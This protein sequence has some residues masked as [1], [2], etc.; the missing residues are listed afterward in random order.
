MLKSSQVICPAPP[1][2]DFFDPR[3]WGDDPHEH[4]VYLTDDLELY[5]V[6]D[7]I[8]Y[9]HCVMKLNRLKAHQPGRETYIPIRWSTLGIKWKN[10]MV[11]PKHYARRSTYEKIGEDG[12]KYE[13]RITGTMVRNQQ[14]TVK[15]EFLHQ[16]IAD[17]MGL[18]VPE[19]FRLDHANGRTLDNRRRNIRV[20]S[21]AFNAANKG[22]KLKH[23]D[24]AEWDR[25]NRPSV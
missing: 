3:S 20:V 13:S 22:G 5:A 19:G 11:N 4:R 24:P 15:S 12:S 23:V 18:V 21:H 6:V 8:D 17:R 9:P 2:L 25:L 14:R 7:A 16:F 1:D 10:G